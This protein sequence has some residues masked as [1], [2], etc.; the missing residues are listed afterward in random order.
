MYDIA[1]ICKDT[2][3]NQYKKHFDRK[4]TLFYCFL[5]INFDKIIMTPEI[6]VII[7]SFILNVYSFGNAVTFIQSISKI[8]G[9]SELSIAP[10]QVPSPP[11]D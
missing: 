2:K 10:A 5:T 7:H 4:N 1:F 9:S 3:K 6:S 8:A 11:N